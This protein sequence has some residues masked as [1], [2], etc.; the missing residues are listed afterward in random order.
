MQELRKKTS[1]E[2]KKKGKK[3]INEDG[4]MEEMKERR[5][6]VWVDAGMYGGEMNF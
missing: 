3:K 1:K 2:R 4:R 6:K 5:I